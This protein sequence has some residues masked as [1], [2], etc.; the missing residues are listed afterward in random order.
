MEFTSNQ[1]LKS[2][3]KNCKKSV[4]EKKSIWKQLIEIIRKKIFNK[5]S[6]INAPASFKYCIIMKTLKIT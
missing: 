1:T 4:G 3:S 2:H 6:W 5:E